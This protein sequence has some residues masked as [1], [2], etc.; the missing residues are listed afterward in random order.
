MTSY[1]RKGDCDEFDDV[2]SVV[3]MGCDFSDDGEVSADNIQQNTDDADQQPNI[4]TS[5]NDIK[6]TNVDWKT[7]PQDMKIVPFL[8]KESLLVP[9]IG[10]TPIDYFR[11]IVSLYQFLQGVV[12]Q[13]NEN[14]INDFSSKSTKKQ[15]S[16]YF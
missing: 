13:T 1:F 2:E 7:N 16:I 8:K 12:D 11:H 14:A 15:S 6:G 10:N 9:P 5:N 3:S 4:V